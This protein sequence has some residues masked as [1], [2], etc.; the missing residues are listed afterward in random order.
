MI[1]GKSFLGLGI[2]FFILVLLII[3]SGFFG[4]VSLSF[5]GILSSE[6]EK[7]I[8]ILRFKRILLGA[9][10]GGMLSLGGA[11][12][13]A[14]LRNPLAEPYI[15]GIS[16]G[17]GLGAVLFII[18]RSASFYYAT[19]GLPLSAF[20][21]SILSF[22]LVQR[23]AKVDGRLSP[24]NLLLS[25][26]VV[27]IVLTNILVFI[28]W[29]FEERL[30]QGIIWWLL[31]N[32]DIMEN[33]ALLIIGLIGLAGLLI[34]LL[35]ARELNIISLGE[36]E[37]ISL[38]IEVEKTKQLLIYISS[39]LTATA[40]AFCGII[41]FVGLIVPHIVRFFS[42]NE[43]RTLLPGSFLMGAIFIVLSDAFAR[44]VL[45][46]IEIP[47]G[48]ITALMG[49]PMFIFLLQRKKKILFK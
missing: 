16:S 47:I 42:G 35:F 44:T 22:L 37:A 21:G 11:I 4:T 29:F 41:G 7:T 39:L 38:G 8:F 3:F 15:L 28:G 6:A 1:K 49:G 36:E 26:V 27:G 30:I 13:Q 25:G 33:T 31:G 43:H 40:V 46:P 9:L 19:L 20:L 45:S 18:L 48:V 12:L 14:V 17:G 24:Q 34:S 5:R 32:L 10:V 23:L 2:L